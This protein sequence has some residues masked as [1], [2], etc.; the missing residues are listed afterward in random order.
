[1]GGF[2]RRSTVTET[3]RRW[4]SVAVERRRRRRIVPCCCPIWFLWVF[5]NIPLKGKV[6]LLLLPIALVFFSREQMI[7]LKFFADGAIQ[8]AAIPLKDLSA[9]F[10]LASA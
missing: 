8:T 2:G 6:S 9:P 5:N 10:K 4:A 1:M 7:R 3:R